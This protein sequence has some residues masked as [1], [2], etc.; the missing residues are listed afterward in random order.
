MTDPANQTDPNLPVTPQKRSPEADAEKRET[1][2]ESTTFD[3][4]AL[5]AL[6]KRMS[7]S[8]AE[9]SMPSSFRCRELTLTIPVEAFRL[10]TFTKPV[11]LT[12]RELDAA[13]ELRAYRAMGMSSDEGGLGAVNTPQQSAEGRGV[14]MALAIGFEALYAFNG[15]PMQDY[16]KEFVWGSLTM[17][18]RLGVGTAFLESG[19]GL[20]DEVMGKISK[21]ATVS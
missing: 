20:D 18:G 9:G 13:A 5:Q 21:S 10:D 2:I 12:L 3:P 14:L 6:I 11:K 1:L 15:R 7:G 19:S 16:E 17:G 8:A 4:N